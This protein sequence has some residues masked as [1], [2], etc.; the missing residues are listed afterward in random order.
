[1]ALA[2]IAQEKADIE[3]SYN[4]KHFHRT[5]KEQ[6]HQLVLLANPIESKFYSPET[7]Y[8]DSL[9]YTPEGKEIYNQMSLAAFT[10]GNLKA[11]PS[12]AFP[13]YILKS[14][15]KGTTEV[16]DGNIA[17]MFTYKEPY[18]A[19]DWTVSDST[20]TILGYDCAM[21]TCEYRGRKWTA[22]FA[23]DIPIQDGPWKLS[24]LPGLI[25]EASE[26]AGQHGFTATGIQTTRRQITPVLGKDH[27]EKTDRIS[28]L[29]ALRK[30]EDNPE[31]GL[32]A[33]LGAKVTVR[34]GI[35]IDKTLDFLETDYK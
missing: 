6:N 12:R 30:F 25:L 31:A 22:W 16:Y 24:G 20:K 33:A 23:V 28:M 7:E 21:A 2:A 34:G 5:G 3:V 4:Y 19:Q 14:K 26:S 8:V 15:T 35:K 18:E 17:M 9:E 11:V 13:M 32:S 27:Y 1:V 29:K 10:S